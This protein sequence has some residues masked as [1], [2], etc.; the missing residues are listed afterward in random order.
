MNRFWLVWCENGGPPTVK[1]TD[2]A[3]AECEAERLA[4]KHR[5]TTFVVLEALASVNVTDVH[6]ERATYELPF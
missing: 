6:W 1:H 4:R 5:G 3:S 2:I